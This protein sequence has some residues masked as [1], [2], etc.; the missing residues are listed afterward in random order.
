MTGPDIVILAGGRATRLGGG[1]KCLLPLAGGPLLG[2]I[3]RRLAGQGGRIALNANGDP[4][5]F[6]G[7]GL[8]VLADAVEGRPGPLAGVLT[9]MEWAETPD[10]LTLPADAPFVPLDLV[11]R[12][13]TAR[14]AAG[15]DIAVA[16]SGGRLHPVSALWPARLA[17]DLR[18]ALGQGVRKVESWIA[19][20]HMVRVTFPTEPIDPFF[21]IN[22]PEDLIEAQ[23]LCRLDPEMPLTE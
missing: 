21:N 11:A 7:F 13:R 8:P 22:R 6:A 16:L 15:A 3:L 10:I 23:R 20:F 17:P 4:A 12:L 2:H 18:R 19:G 14:A 9:A 1:D 5:R